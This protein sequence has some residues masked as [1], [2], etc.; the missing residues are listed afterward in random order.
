MSS[1]QPETG[2]G[3]RRRRGEPA[4]RRLPNGA[5]LTE[6]R[7]LKVKDLAGLRRSCGPA[8]ATTRST[9]TP[10]SAWRPRLGLE[11]S[12]RCWSALPASPS[13]TVTPPRWPR[14]SGTTSRTNPLLV[15]KGGVL[16][17]KMIGAAETAALA[18]LPSREILLASFAGAIA[19]PLQQWRR[20]SRPCPGIW[21]TGWPPCATR[22]AEGASEA[23]AAAPRPPPRRRTPRRAGRETESRPP[24]TAEPTG[25]EPAEP[26]DP[27]PQ[28]ADR[29]AEAASRGRRREPGPVRHRS[30]RR[31][32]PR[33]T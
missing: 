9:R 29:A 30:T 27:E 3:S 7:G 17:D 14:C 12:R 24:E 18:D 4:F 26:A 8:A 20:C 19:A 6:Y 31:V 33:S 25:R 5:I 21:P 13:S 22:S 15:I 16:G 11:E 2:E 1:G 10:W 32:N 28:T 23:A